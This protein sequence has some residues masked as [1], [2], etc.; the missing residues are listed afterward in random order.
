MGLALILSQ[1]L[2]LHCG[3][4]LGALAVDIARQHFLLQCDLIGRSS[5]HPARVY[6][7]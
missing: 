4:V 5:P 7:P 1:D 2:R 6:D 3:L